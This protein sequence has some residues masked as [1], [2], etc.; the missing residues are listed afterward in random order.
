MLSSELIIS[1]PLE[2]TSSSKAWFTP[3]IQW[4]QERK[5]DVSISPFQLST[6]SRQLLQTELP[7]YRHL[8]LDSMT[9]LS[10]DCR[11]SLQVTG[12]QARKGKKKKQ[13]HCFLF[14]KCSQLWH[15]TSQAALMNTCLFVSE[16][17]C[18]GVICSSVIHS[19]RL[20][21]NNSLFFFFFLPEVL[22]RGS[23]TFKAHL[24]L[25]VAGVEVEG[26][27][28]LLPLLLLQRSC[29]LN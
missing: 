26:R 7:H 6:K 15:W 27:D 23:S 16:T 19:E 13:T 17:A 1:A 9:P 10:W 20:K 25:R 11:W 5:A 21:E 8:N 14:T 29:H 18:W 4:P 24:K 28:Q 2:E 3:R 22:I 12:L